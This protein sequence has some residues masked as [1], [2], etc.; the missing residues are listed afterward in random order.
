MKYLTQKGIFFLLAILLKLRGGGGSSGTF[1]YIIY[2]KSSLLSIK[3]K[4]YF[5]SAVA[6]IVKCSVVAKSIRSLSSCTEIKA[7]S[8]T[9]K[10]NR[11]VGFSI[12]LKKIGLPF[13]NNNL[14]I[15]IFCSLYRYKFALQNR[16]EEQNPWEIMW[17]G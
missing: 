10:M 3:Q 9:V 5:S 17:Q 12:V 13:K 1:C 14:Y 15:Y 16:P 2:T 11:F 7:S 4:L 6:S 8:G